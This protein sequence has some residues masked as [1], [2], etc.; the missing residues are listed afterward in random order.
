MRIG[1]G[2]AFSLF[3]M[4][5]VAAAGKD[6]K[7]A[8]LPVDVL[9]AKTVL[10][11]IDPQAGMALDAPNA[12]QSARDAVERA[13]MDWG[14]FELA[15]DVSTAD[16]I[17][18]VRKGNGKMVEPTIGGLPNN[19]RPVIYQPTDS[20]GRVG[21]SRG[22]PPM[23]DPNSSPGMGPSPQIEAGPTDDMFEVYRGK[24]EDPLD[25]PAVWRYTA[26]DALNAPSVQAVSAFRKA[27]VEAEN[28]QGNKP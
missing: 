16:L 8:V 10:V 24:R 13:L 6:K 20:G 14:R 12:N 15:M 7:K 9:E 22:T 23:T 27:M 18:T 1:K 26:K 5:C 3:L 11:L 4:C 17:I 21:A 19:Q 25:S 2:L 28:Q